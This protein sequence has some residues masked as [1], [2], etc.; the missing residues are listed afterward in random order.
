[1]SVLLSMMEFVL[2]SIAYTNKYRLEV[3][4]FRD[5]RDDGVVFGLP[6]DF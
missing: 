2:F 6:T 1:M 3:V 5:G 4:G